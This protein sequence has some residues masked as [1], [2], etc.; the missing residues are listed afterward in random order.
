M[1]GTAKEELEPGT[2]FVGPDGRFIN[3]E[4]SDVS[5]DTLDKLVLTLVENQTGTKIPYVKIKRACEKN[6]IPYKERG[7]LPAIP[8]RKLF[9]LAPLPFSTAE[10]CPPEAKRLKFTERILFYGLSLDFST[11]CPRLAFALS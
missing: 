2:Y 3:R 1:I 11:L 7:E 4:N 8:M 6:K 5:M 10:L 9:E